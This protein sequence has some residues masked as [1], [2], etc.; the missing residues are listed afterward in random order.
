MANF[1]GLEGWQILTTDYRAQCMTAFVAVCLTL[2]APYVFRIL[3]RFI[4]W[5]GGLWPFK[6]SP[7][8]S[9]HQTSEAQPLLHEQQ[10]FNH[11]TTSQPNGFSNIILEHP[12]QTVGDVAASLQQYE[13]SREAVAGFIHR[14]RNGGQRFLTST[15]MVVLAIILF[16]FFVVQTIAGIFSAKIATDRAALSSSKYCGIWK[17]DRNAG[18]E[19]SD[20]DDIYNY[21]K[22]ATASQ[23]AR[24]C[25]SAPSSAGSLGCNFFYNQSIDYSTKSDQPCPFQSPELCL[26]GLYSAV[27]FDTG[28]VDASVLGINFPST[29]KFRRVTSCSPLNMNGSYVQGP[30][31]EDMDN[32]T[33]YYHYGAKDISNSTF[34]TSGTPFQWLVPVYSVK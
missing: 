27:Q 4:A 23:Y 24:N 13:S 1:C 14:I 31:S 16:G 15:F 32:N 33:Y 29:H 18:G 34:K 6:D 10:F 30:S 3:S 28:I 26:N 9:S 21:Q 19:A 7:T 11:A 20:R 22:E 12:Y 2:T 25:Y 8:S 5:I 17:F